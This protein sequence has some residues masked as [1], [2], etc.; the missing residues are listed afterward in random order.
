MN[1]TMNWLPVFSG[2][3]TLL[4]IATNLCMARPTTERHPINHK[5]LKHA[6]IKAIQQEILSKLGLTEVPDVSQF[7]TTVE[8]K[9]RMIKLYK[10]SLEESQGQYHDLFSEEEFYAKKFNSFKE[11]G[12]YLLFIPYPTRYNRKYIVLI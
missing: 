7:N 9:R 10:K 12:K 3:L 1:S 8:E 6:R 2:I 5:R 4:E 11:V